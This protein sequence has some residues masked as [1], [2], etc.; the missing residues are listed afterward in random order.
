MQETEA[1]GR[2]GDWELGLVVSCLFALVF[3]VLFAAALF[4]A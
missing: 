4:S 3:G 2:I 1:D